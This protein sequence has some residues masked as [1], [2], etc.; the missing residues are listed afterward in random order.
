MYGAPRTTADVRNDCEPGQVSSDRPEDTVRH[1][2]V[3][4]RQASWRGMTFLRRGV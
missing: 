4:L 3:E 2:Q 1:D